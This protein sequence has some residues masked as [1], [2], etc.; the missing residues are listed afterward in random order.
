VARQVFDS[1][2]IAGLNIEYHLEML[3]IL[4]GE[5]NVGLT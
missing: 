1:F 5:L 3:S 2:G 4:K